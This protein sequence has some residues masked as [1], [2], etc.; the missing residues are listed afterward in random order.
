MVC[1]TFVHERVVGVEDIEDASVFAHQVHEERLGFLPHR[2][3]ELFVE[4]RILP[5]V[6]EEV[7]QVLQPQPLSRKP[8][9]QGRGARVG[10]HP[11]H[12]LIE[13][14][15]IGELSVQG[16]LGQLIIGRRRPEEE[17]EARCQGKVAEM[18]RLARPDVARHPLETED[19]VRAGEDRLQ[20]RTHPLLEAAPGGT[21]V[22][23]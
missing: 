9:G 3:S 5:H 18:D 16:E 22:E 2:G 8:G 4:V 15:P 21:R 12:L 10:Q 1:Q 19:E 14:P 7:V 11:H 6:G 13:Y 20:S 17:R 23:E